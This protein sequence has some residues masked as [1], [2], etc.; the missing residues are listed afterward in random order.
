MGFIINDQSESEDE[1]VGYD[2]DNSLINGNQYNGRPAD[3]LFSMDD[4]IATFEQEQEEERKRSQ[5]GS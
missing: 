3:D 2:T 5:Q 4:I 1:Q